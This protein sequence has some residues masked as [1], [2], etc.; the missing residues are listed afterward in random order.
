MKINIARL[1]RVAL[2]AAGITGAAHGASI[3]LIP[4]GG[5]LT[6][7][8][9]STVGWGFSLTN[10]TDFLQITSSEFCLDSSGVTTA[11][12][13][14]TIGTYTDFIGPNGPVAGPPPESPT[15]TQAFDLGTQQGAGSFTISA[16]APVGAQNTGQI[17]FFYN[18]YSVSPNDPNFNPVTD[19]LATD[20]TLTAAAS[21]TVVGATGVPEPATFGFAGIAIAALVTLRRKS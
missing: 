8:P 3:T 11:C 4:P 2:L 19:T 12:Q 14:P 18:L 21:V 20:Q 15:V 13:L 17:V 6:G 7:T 5:A 16:A 1:A 10:T 9:G